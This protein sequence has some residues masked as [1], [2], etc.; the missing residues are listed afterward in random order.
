MP[1]TKQM[2]SCS[3]NCLHRQFV[4]QYRLAR[5]AAERKREDETAGYPAEM[6]AY[7]PIMTFKQWLQDMVGWNTP[8]EEGLQDV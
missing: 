5:E 7:P 3:T 8:P 2:R 4:E 6:A 1:C